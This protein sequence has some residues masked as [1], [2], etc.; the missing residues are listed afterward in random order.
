M[1]ERLAVAGDEKLVLMVLGILDSN[2]KG[3]PM[4]IKTRPNEAWNSGVS[5]AYS[6]AQQYGGTTLIWTFL[7]IVALSA[8]VVAA[9]NWHSISQLSPYWPPAHESE[10]T[11]GKSDTELGAGRKSDSDGL[12][13]RPTN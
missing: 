10:H 9:T 7:S 4:V 13:Q 1:F 12:P 3:K 5:R 11:T 6:S 8:G 2:P